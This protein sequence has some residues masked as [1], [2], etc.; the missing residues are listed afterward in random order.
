MSI[1]YKDGQIEYISPLVL[2]DDSRDHIAEVQ[3]L[4]GD[5]MDQQYVC[6]DGEAAVPFEKRF[7]IEERVAVDWC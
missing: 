7:S 1:V 3:Y 4:L 5:A 6:D 2:S